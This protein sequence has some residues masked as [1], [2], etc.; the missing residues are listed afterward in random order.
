MYIRLSRSRDRVL[1]HCL[2][3]RLLW[4]R[5]AVSEWWLIIMSDW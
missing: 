3:Q 1:V 5:A 2:L 4:F